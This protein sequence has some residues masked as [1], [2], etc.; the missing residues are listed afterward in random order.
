MQ[1]QMTPYFIV[2][3]IRIKC[4]TES[5]HCFRGATFDHRSKRQLILTCQKRQLIPPTFDPRVGQ[6]QMSVGSNVAKS[7]IECRYLGSYV[8]GIKCR[9]YRLSPHP[10]SMS[11]SQHWL[12]CI[13]DP[14]LDDI[15]V[16]TGG[17]GKYRA[18]HIL[19]HGFA[20]LAFLAYQSYSL[21]IFTSRSIHLSVLCVKKSCRYMHYYGVN[22]YN[23][24]K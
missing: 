12:N 19:C 10:S 13:R 24:K 20:R 9:W 23:N 17:A 8:V 1:T 14:T 5:A 18:Y 22:C 6:D 11:W 16:H 2:F 15:G 7:R 21:D 4:R 3:G